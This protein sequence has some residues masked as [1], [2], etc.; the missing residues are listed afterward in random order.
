MLLKRTTIFIA[1]FIAIINTCFSQTFI[2]QI[3][4]GDVMPKDINK[5]GYSEKENA[6]CSCR[7]FYTA[8]DLDDIGNTKMGT[9]AVTIGIH[10]ENDSVVGIIE[11]QMRMSNSDAL[12]VYIM[13]M[14][15]ILKTLS[16][17]PN[18]KILSARTSKKGTVDGI[19][20]FGY[21]DDNDKTRTM[22]G[23]VGNTIIVEK[24]KV[25]SNYQWKLHG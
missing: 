25:D 4:V 24:Y 6:D 23:V 1:T 10:H 21:T 13:R 19:Y 11:T 16:Y 2:D 14:S 12:Q 9:K 7:V 15:D 8:Y 17:Y 18:R 20:Y 22:I 3:K 5:G